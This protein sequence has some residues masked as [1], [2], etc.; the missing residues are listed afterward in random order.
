MDDKV[1]TQS[2]GVIEV[3]RVMIQVKQPPFPRGVVGGGGLR[4]YK[5][6]EV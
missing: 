4:V 5:E 2:D 6:K 3:W 1:D